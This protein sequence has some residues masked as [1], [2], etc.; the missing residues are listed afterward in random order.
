MY[1]HYKLLSY[2][3]RP[4]T[5][6]MADRLDS[7]QPPRSALEEKVPWPRIEEGLR[8]AERQLPA[9]VDPTSEPG[10]A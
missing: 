6:K 9:G 5:L 8:D 4:D 2:S 10:Q 3:P 1:H 7:Q